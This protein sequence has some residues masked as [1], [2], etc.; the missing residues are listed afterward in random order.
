[1][2]FALSRRWW[3]DGA[4]CA[5][6]ASLLMS[7][8]STTGTGSTRMGSNSSNALRGLDLA[9]WSSMSGKPRAVVDRSASAA[10]VCT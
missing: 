9:R 5:L 4:P 1:M 3:A 7:F 10:G 2:V 8:A 6:L